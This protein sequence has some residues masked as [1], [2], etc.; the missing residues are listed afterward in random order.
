MAHYF[1]NYMYN[2]LS[3][4]V[5]YRVLF[6]MLSI[7]SASML[8]AQTNIDVTKLLADT[9]SFNFNDNKST[10]KDFIYQE[11]EKKTLCCGEDRIYVEVRVHPTGHVVEAKTLTGKNDCVKSSVIDIVK[12]IKWDAKDFKGVKPIYFEVRPNVKCSGDRKNT[13]AAV[14][15]FNNPL[16]TEDGKL[17]D[18]SVANEVVL[19]GGNKREEPVTSTEVVPPATPSL[20]EN[21]QTTP[22]T[23]IVKTE[24]K[25]TVKA[26]NNIPAV[27][28]TPKMEEPAP[29]TPVNEPALVIKTD[30]EKNTNKSPIQ[31]VKTEAVA[32]TEK[33]TAKP[34]QTET[35]PQKEA[36]I[37][38]LQNQLSELRSKQE[39][40]Q[41]AQQRRED[42]L[43]QREEMRLE[44]QRQL[45]EQRRQAEADP[46]KNVVAG[47]DEKPAV[48]SNPEQD[49]L[50]RLRKER[51][52]IEN[53]RRELEEARRRD[54]MEQDRYAKE[55]LRIEEQIRQKEEEI[56]RRREQDE[57]DRMNEDRRRIESNRGELEGEMRRLVD[58]IQRLQDEL[59]RKTVELEQKDFEIQRLGESISQREQEIQNE[60]LL[61]EQNMQAELDLMRKRT[62]LS[63]AMGTGTLPNIDPNLINQLSNG[64]NSDAMIQQIILMQ[65]EMERLQQQIQRLQGGGSTVP[66]SKRADTDKSWQ[67]VN[68]SRPGEAGNTSSRPN[69][70]S[71]PLRGGYDPVNG[72]SPDKS[73][74][75][76]YANVAGP[77]Y[78]NLTYG[79]GQDA[80]NRFI[81]DRLRAGGVCGTA[82]AFAEVTI[83]ARGNVIDRKVLKGS[84]TKVLILMPEILNNLKFQPTFLNVPQVSYIEFKANIRCA[85]EVVPVPTPVQPNNQGNSPGSGNN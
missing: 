81:E 72:F 75:G 6:A 73:H 47:T 13:Y 2:Q 59:G 55:F 41:L 54:L 32:Q 18:P 30:V 39:E 61:R 43:R 31:E 71:G 16:L 70:G 8:Q 7:G 67:D 15:V 21:E 65:Q 84:N 77:R 50:E 19:G 37:K 28:E 20:P 62:E 3:R 79:S 11:L 78:R 29:K 52:E 10:V 68:Y 27:V 1:L 14:A 40:M 34:E 9:K 80:M 38:Q 25:E 44:R 46:F 56:N 83:D 36:E 76:T 82:E 23:D 49:E 85:N 53:R 57:L 24:T 33:E 5:K 42:V 45:E 63:A 4:V 74:E 12:N 51:L 22:A 35:D 26:E 69:Q 58:E 17:K 66:G 60:R 48:S 64:E